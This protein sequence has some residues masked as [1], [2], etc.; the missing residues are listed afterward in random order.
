MKHVGYLVQ[1]ML[2]PRYTLKSALFSSPNSPSCGSVP[3]VALLPGAGANSPPSSASNSPSVVA[4][5]AFRSAK[6]RAKVEWPRLAAPFSAEAKVARSRAEGEAIV[7][8]LYR[9][10]GDLPLLLLLLEDD[11]GVGDRA[12][13]LAAEVADPPPPATPA[14][15]AFTASALPPPLPA[16]RVF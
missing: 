8:D 15:F 9:D 11:D 3:P 13:A 16:L 2:A 12:L 7:G 10:P 1:P 6:S 5:A 14:P 4:A